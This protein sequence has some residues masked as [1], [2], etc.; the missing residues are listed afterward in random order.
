MISLY[1]LQF[2]CLLYVKVF[3]LFFFIFLFVKRVSEL[4]KRKSY[5]D[6]FFILLYLSPNN[7]SNEEPLC[8]KRYRKILK[9][10]IGIDYA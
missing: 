2:L 5:G 8:E 10:S 7:T 4:V 9:T 3:Y 6:R 1:T